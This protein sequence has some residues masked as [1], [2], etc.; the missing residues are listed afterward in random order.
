MCVCV[1]LY[2]RA[3]L[4]TIYSGL[5]NPSTAGR[6]YN[7]ATHI[8]KLFST[9][10]CRVIYLIARHR[11]AAPK[12]KKIKDPWRFHNK[13]LYNRCAYYTNCVYSTKHCVFYASS[14][15]NLEKMVGRSQ[16]TVNILS[17]RSNLTWRRETYGTLLFH[18]K[19]KMIF[20][21]H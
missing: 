21:A 5:A 18:K 14:L 8:G 13:I 15:I 19:K 4:E 20:G 17:K 2:N 7:S 10:S 16:P 12:E 11:P 9:S 3:V 6:L 1:C